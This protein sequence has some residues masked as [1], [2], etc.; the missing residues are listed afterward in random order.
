ML[1][2]KF[3]IQCHYHAFIDLYPLV[4]TNMIDLSISDW[5]SVLLCE[6]NE[7]QQIY[8]IDLVYWSDIG[9]SIVIHSLVHSFTYVIFNLIMLGDQVTNSNFP[10]QIVPRYRQIKVVNGVVIA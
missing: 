5:T 7:E 10:H 6:K 2:V 8:F 1:K 3:I 4:F 9:Y